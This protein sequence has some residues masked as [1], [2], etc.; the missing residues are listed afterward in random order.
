MPVSPVPLFDGQPPESETDAAWTH[1]TAYVQSRG[2]LSKPASLAVYTHMWQS[3]A[4]WLQAQRIGLP[5]LN[6]AQLSRFLDERSR[7]SEL[8]PRH[9]WRLVR[10]I[11]RVIQFE[12]MRLAY[13]PSNACA[14][15]LARRPDIQYA[16]AS[17]QDGLPEALS[18]HEAATL[19]RWLS[20]GEPATDARSSAAWKEVR[21]RAAIGLQ[22][23]A[24]LTPGE[25]RAL[26]L[27][28]VQRAAAGLA[29]PQRP[30]ALTLPAHGN[31][32]AHTVQLNGWPARLL[33][34]W[35]TLRGELEFPGSMVF[36]STRS[37]GA[38]WGKVAH[39]EAVRKALAAAG[40]GQ[41]DGGS[42]RL[43]HTY[44]LR[45]LRRGVTPAE[46]SR[47]LGVTDPDVMDRYQRLLA[48]REES[49]VEEFEN[50]YNAR[51]DA[52]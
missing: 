25:I 46:L 39:Y 40:L 17:Q 6:V 43:R 14:E 31:S 36:P 11:D 12:A 48:K 8:S 27:R 29:V 34:E 23:G 1:W 5:D 24:G 20:P 42:Y 35:L 51:L 44:A 33:D 2:L 32:P 7:E 49:Q 45:Q 52:W 3:F 4:T 15:L 19:L 10:L 28:H 38:A 30:A 16:N 9:A 22:L 41:T 13:P 47:R 50:S 26:E 37:A 18:A 21:I